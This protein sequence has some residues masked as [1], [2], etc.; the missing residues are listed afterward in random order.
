MDVTQLPRK[1]CAIQNSS[2]KEPIRQTENLLITTTF[3]FPKI[4]RHQ[5]TSCKWVEK[6]KE[7]NK[8]K[9]MIINS[10]IIKFFAHSFIFLVLSVLPP[11]KTYS[12]ASTKNNRGDEDETRKIFSS[13][14]DIIM[15]LSQY[16][17]YTFSY[18]VLFSIYRWKCTLH[19]SNLM[20]IHNFLNFLPFIIF[21]PR[22][23]SR[24]AVLVFSLFCRKKF[25]IG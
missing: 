13:F 16:T 20:R 3:S 10:R 15:P 17:K 1:D 14:S 11:Q 24:L 18:S 9:F 6:M 4:S 7:R 22:Y 21:A 8:K 19:R 23:S 2:N 25:D 5:A 12:S